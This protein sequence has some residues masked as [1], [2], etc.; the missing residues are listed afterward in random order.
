MPYHYLNQEILA[1]LQ[2]Q[3]QH[4]MCQ[5]NHH[6]C[7]QQ[8]NSFWAPSQAQLSTM[9]SSVHSKKTLVELVYE[10]QKVH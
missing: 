4:L 6:K 8:P 2:A 1:E 7:P 3:T 10:K 5:C 9:V